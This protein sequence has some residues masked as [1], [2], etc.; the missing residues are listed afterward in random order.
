MS[1]TETAIFGVYRYHD[2]NT[3]SL[4]VVLNHADRQYQL[5]IPSG[6]TIP[7]RRYLA[8]DGGK[9]DAKF[10]RWAPDGLPC[11]LPDLPDFMRAWTAALSKHFIENQPTIPAPVTPP[12][13]QPEP[14]A[15]SGAASAIYWHNGVEEVIET[16]PAQRHANG[17]IEARQDAERQAIQNLGQQRGASRDVITN[18]P[19]SAN[20]RQAV[21]NEAARKNIDQISQAARDRL[22]ARGR[23]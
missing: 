11:R 13:P 7:I 22:K 14:S 17:W 23:G 6:A 15:P 12:E 18:A 21:L 5:K 16:P 10:L 9:P 20:P 8:V 1:I 3:I 2:G 19:E 4:P